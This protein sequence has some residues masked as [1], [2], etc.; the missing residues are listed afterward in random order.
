MRIAHLFFTVAPT[1]RETAL[2]ALMAQAPAIRNMTGCLAF[3]P[4]LDPSEGGK[5]GVI[6][7]WESPADFE[8]Y[9]ASD[10]FASLSRLLRPMMMGPPVSKRFD[11]VSLQTVN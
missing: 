11:A 10:P 6:H 7:E 3:V 4:F 5:L 8:A 9:I 2:Q 1:Q